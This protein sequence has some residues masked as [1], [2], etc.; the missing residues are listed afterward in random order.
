MRH[1][2]PFNVIHKPVA[3]VFVLLTSL[4]I[5]T[6]WLTHA[7]SSAAAN[8]P[9]SNETATLHDVKTYTCPMHPEVLSHERGRCPECKMFLVEQ[10]A[11]AQMDH[12]AHSPNPGHP[13][14]A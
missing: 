4:L 8:K 1:M 3:K 12:E 13:H 9:H 7:H 6:S 14:A 11:E 5:T 10:A 2:N